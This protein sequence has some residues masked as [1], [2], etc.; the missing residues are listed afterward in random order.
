LFAQFQRFFHLMRKIN[1]CAVSAFRQT[2][3]LRHH[4]RC[5]PS[6][7]LGLHHVAHPHPTPR[8]RVYVGTT[9]SAG[10]STNLAI[11]DADEHYIALLW[12]VSRDVRARAITNFTLHTCVIPWPSLH[13]VGI[14]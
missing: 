2:V 1:V 9:P 12:V 7:Q 5:L 6:K 8:P 4:V 11:S 14:P 13:D 3:L 10:H